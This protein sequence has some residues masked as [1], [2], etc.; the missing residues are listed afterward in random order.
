MKFTLAAALF[1]VA[2]GD[3]AAAEVHSKLLEGHLRSG[4]NLDVFVR[5]LGLFPDT[6]PEGYDSRG[7]LP[8]YFKDKCANCM[9]LKGGE[10]NPV[11]RF[12]CDLSVNPDGTD[13]CVDKGKTGSLCTYNWECQSNDCGAFIANSP[14]VCF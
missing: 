8:E 14:D 1:A 3:A 12:H 10:G 6:Y 7:C 5:R 9:C 4:D 13:H 2:S 11:Q